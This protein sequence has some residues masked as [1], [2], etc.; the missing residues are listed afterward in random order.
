MILQSN[1]SQGWNNFQLFLLGE[2]TR[3]YSTPVM[4]I[5]ENVIYLNQ[6]AS[7]VL[8]ST[9]K[10]VNFVSQSWNSSDLLIIYDGKQLLSVVAEYVD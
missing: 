2:I 10:V 4:S 8:V 1:T 7:F 6:I 9:F 5:I 3:N